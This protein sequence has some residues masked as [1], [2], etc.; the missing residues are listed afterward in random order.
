METLQSTIFIEFDV[1]T[2]KITFLRGDNVIDCDSNITNIYVR[3]KYKN[4][5]GNTVYLTPSELEGYKFSLYTIKPATN[6]VNI[7]T[8]E[9]T[10]E[11]KENVYGGVVKFEIPRV[12]TNR[13]GI[14]KCEIHINQENRMIASSKF[15]LDVKQSLVTAFDDEL[16]GDE[17]FPVLRQLILEI[18]K[19]S[20]I[21]DNNISK[22]TTYSSDKIETIK[23]N[24][25]SQIKEKANATDV[26]KKGQVSL[27]ECTEDMLNAIQGGEDTSFN[28][29]SIPRNNS[30]TIGKM[31]DDFENLGSYAE[32]VTPSQVKEGW[33]DITTGTYY[34]L[35][36]WNL[37]YY[38]V[39]EGEKYKYICYSWENASAGVIF[40]DVNDNMISY[41]HKGIGSEEKHEGEL[42]IP[43]G[44]VKMALFGRLKTPS[45]I[46]FSININLNDLEK[47]V[48]NNTLIINQSVNYYD[49]DVDLNNGYYNRNDLTLS[50]SPNYNMQYANVNVT[51]G[52]KYKITCG[53]SELVVAGVIFVDSDGTKISTILDGTGSN[54]T[55]QDYEF[56]VPA[57]AVKMYITNR[58]DLC[59]FNLKKRMLTKPTR[60]TGDINDVFI[61]M[62][63]SSMYE[64]DIM[65]KYSSDKDMM[66]KLMTGGVNNLLTTRYFYTID[67]NLEWCCGDFSK[68]QTLLK[69]VYSDMIGPIRVSAVNNADGNEETVGKFTGG[70]HGT[71]TNDKPSARLDS[72]KF[73]ID[74]KE[75]TGT[76]GTYKGKEVRIE[77]INYLQGWNTTNSTGTGREILT[78]KVTMIITRG[79]IDVYNELTALEDVTMGEYYG[80]QTENGGAWNDEILFLC[81][82]ACKRK[83]FTVD[84]DCPDKVDYIICKKDNHY[85][86]AY[87][88]DCG[89][90]RLKYNKLSN[91]K[92]HSRAYGKTYFDLIADNEAFRLSQNDSVWWHGGYILSYGTYKLD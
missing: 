55:Y 92:A 5:S 41:L 69:N 90:G 16:L 37:S 6:N 49:I 18:Q 70:W 81:D 39:I 33:F 75:I 13:L 14:V 72:I 51:G 35:S 79:K 66:I 4:L 52:E 62:K 27:N 17:D 74:N 21:D 44:C 10:D 43:E 80:I 38:D 9:V 28:I 67:N 36:G 58:Y 8:G 76:V 63:N 30:V 40:L 53:V 61:K 71:V 83:D 59:T 15:V 19:A 31:T 47:A 50:T 32:N 2:K 68:E 57:N 24:L 54:E 23:E 89:L 45:A 1:N 56:A 84:Y 42:V 60:E 88:K 11:L 34:D 22:I 12:C 86:T 91:R 73:F 20:N 26:V 25:S 65:F 29:L 85:L 82:G 64:T 48:A 77:Y 3:V 87:I 46:R 7:I 78:E